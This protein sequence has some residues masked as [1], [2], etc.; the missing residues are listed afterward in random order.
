VIAYIPC[1]SAIEDVT[2]KATI[3]VYNNPSVSDSPTGAPGGASCSLGQNH[4]RPATGGFATANGF[5]VDLPSPLGTGDFTVEFWIYQT[6]W[7]DPDDQASEILIT[8]TVYPHNGSSNFP[9]FWSSS[10]PDA[11]QFTGNIKSFVDSGSMLERWTNY[12]ASRVA[13]T[14]YIF[15]DGKLLM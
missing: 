15:R 1:T 6:A 9:S 12:A 4:K 2:H 5:A 13:G 10:P 7:H 3:T 11:V 14:T 8:N